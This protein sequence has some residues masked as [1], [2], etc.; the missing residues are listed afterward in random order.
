MSLGL[1]NPELELTKTEAEIQRDREEKA[2]RLDNWSRLKIYLW[3]DDSR[4]DQVVEVV[5]GLMEGIGGFSGK[6]NIQRKHLK[7][8]LLNLYANFLE[9]PTNTPGSTEWRTNTSPRDATTHYT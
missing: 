2:V 4:V 6:T 9:D 1:H 5:Y 7:V 8:I 3:S